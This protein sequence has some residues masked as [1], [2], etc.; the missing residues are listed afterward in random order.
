M[1]NSLFDED[2]YIQERDAL[3]EARGEIKALQRAVITIVRGRF[4]PLVE[5]AQQKVTKLNKPDAL[6]L[7]VEQVSTAPDEEMVRWLL[8]ALAA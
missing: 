8:K 5:L 3:A 1:Y 6:N 2:P 7:L 4:P